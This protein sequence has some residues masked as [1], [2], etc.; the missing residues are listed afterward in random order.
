MESV[1]R[2]IASLKNG[3]YPREQFWMDVLASLVMAGRLTII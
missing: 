3:K 2:F 1:K